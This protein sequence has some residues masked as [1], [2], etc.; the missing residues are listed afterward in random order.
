MLL[1]F[2]TILRFGELLKFEAYTQTL[3]A[4]STS[5]D[6]GDKEAR[7]NEQARSY[8][9]ISTGASSIADATTTTTAA[10]RSLRQ[11]NSRCRY[12]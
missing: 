4:Q 1:G 3:P 6:V 11:I 10:A 9:A 5:V 2:G 8:S 12:R 7:E